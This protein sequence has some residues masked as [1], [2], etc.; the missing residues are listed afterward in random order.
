MAVENKIFAGGGMNSNN[1][2]EFVEQP[3]FID[4]TNL[5]TI[6]GETN[7]QG[8][9]VAIEGNVLV[10]APYSTTG[11]NVIKS[12]YF[13]EIEKAILFVKGATNS[14]HFIA[15]YDPRT[16][17]FIKLIQGATLGF[18]TGYLK[19]IKLVDKKFLVWNKIGTEVRIINIERAISGAYSSYT[20]ADISLI[21]TPP[22]QE[23]DISIVDVVTGFNKIKENSLQFR[24]QFVYMDN[25]VSAWSPISNT[26]YPAG[27]GNDTSLNLNNGF[28]IGVNTGSKWVKEVITA[29]RSNDKSDWF[30]IDRVL[31]SDL[32]SLP[33]NPTPTLIAPKTYNSGINLYQFLFLNNGLY[34]YV[35]V[36]ETDLLADAIPRL[37]QSVEVANKNILLL[38]GTYEGYSR[39]TLSSVT[40][41]DSYQ[42]VSIPSTTGF[43]IISQEHTLKPSG[44]PTLEKVNFSSGHPS[45]GDIITFVQQRYWDF[46]HEPSSSYSYTFTAAD[47][48]ASLSTALTTMAQ[49]FTDLGIASNP[50]W[51]P[52]IFG[53]TVDPSPLTPSVTFHL[54]RVSGGGFANDI[55]WTGTYANS[56]ISSN[57]ISIPT[58]KGGAT[59]QIALAH[60]DK[61]GRPFPIIT[62]DKFKA[63]TKTLGELNL[64]SLLVDKK[65]PT[66]TWNLGSSTP[67][68]GAVT[69]KWLVTLNQTYQNWVQV[70]AT[71]VEEIN[72]T[73]KYDVTSLKRYADANSFTSVTYDFVSGDRAR[74]LGTPE[75]Y[76]GYNDLDVPIKKFEIVTETNEAEVEE[77][78]YYIT[79]EKPTASIPALGNKQVL[80][81]Y[82]P[83]K[84]SVDSVSNVFYE[85]GA[86]YLITNGQYQTKTGVIEHVDNFY[87]TRVMWDS[88]TTSSEII[89]EDPNFSNRYASRWLNTGRVRTYYDTPEGVQYD[90]RIRYSDQYMRGTEVN[91]LNRFYP[92]N[93]VDYDYIYGLIQYL[94]IRGNR[95]VCLQEKNIGYI[96]VYQS[97]LE[98]AD[99]SEN[100]AVSTRLLNQIQYTEGS[101]T[102]IGNAL[103][104]Y[105]FKDN[106]I[107]FIDPFKE[108]VMRAGLDGVIDIGYNYSIAIRDRI[109]S[110]KNTSIQPNSFS[111]L[112][113]NKHNEYWLTFADQDDT[114]VFSKSSNKW[115][116]RVT[117]EPDSGFSADNLLHTTKSGALYEHNDTVA[118]R[119]T[120]Y[121][122]T[123][124]PTL[125]F[126]INNNRD[127]I[128]I[129][130]KINIRSTKLLI[131]TDGGIVTQLNHVSD[132]KQSDFEL[133]DYS[134]SLEG[135]YRA[136]F[137]RANPDPIE[138]DRLQGRYCTIELQAT[139]NSFKLLDVNVTYKESLPYP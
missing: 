134:D 44:E 59:Y 124:K 114:L 27:S 112:F 51:L 83:L 10:P 88:D 60:Y 138:G 90:A 31:T 45:E 127:L 40:V 128:K 82:T 38:G 84:N 111:T 9:T 136:N 129:F 137:L 17:T 57:S 68:A 43:R 62:G 79:I 47:E 119:A 25:E 23:P 8:Y 50:N 2:P 55:H 16:K 36:L 3:D 20:E 28:I 7:E 72:G 121:G 1:A 5:R 56:D 69:Y 86:T 115:T 123:Y 113:N 53:F 105:L 118:P 42:T 103:G 58:L 22:L 6:S 70:L 122:V 65:V 97:I 66:I 61:Y 85:T 26:L 130:Q 4:A 125:K 96:A 74:I 108:A 87:K 100:I 117:E 41:A 89:V 139:D 95:L 48:A 135:V 35:D 99:M 11:Q 78:F 12:V 132:L 120:L 39:P 110:V 81:L 46:G 93:F 116:F 75:I 52:A 33:N 73:L 101:D 54:T 19:D 126:V 76:A 34:E 107:Y 109:R 92:E 80:E 30:V 131:T 37:A 94:T 24:S 32:T 106:S 64:T 15:Q 67:P 18:E 13:T 14:T 71:F 98:N 102:G 91:K 49:Y 77:T 104:S 63:T 29:A 21:K 133:T